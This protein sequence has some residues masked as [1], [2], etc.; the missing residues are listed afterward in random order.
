MSERF[1]P[2]CAALLLAVCGCASGRIGSVHLADR[3]VL[4]SDAESPIVAVATGSG[5]QHL[6]GNSIVPMHPSGRWAVVSNAKTGPRWLSWNE[7]DPSGAGMVVTLTDTAFK[8]IDLETGQAIDIP[9]GFNAGDREI[10]AAC[11]AADTLVVEVARK[12]QNSGMEYHSTELPGADWRQVLPRRWGE[13]RRPAA[14]EVKSPQQFSTS[15]DVGRWGRLVQVE[16]T[17]GREIVLVREGRPDL[18]VL[19]RGDSGK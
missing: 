9:H 12:Y 13:A 2:I 15:V 11:V 1:L 6:N 14:S 16:R 17:F 19:K 8:A 5:V 4:V 18:V 7:K 3:G 10:R